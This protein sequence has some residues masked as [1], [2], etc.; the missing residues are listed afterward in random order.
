MTA[1]KLPCPNIAGISLSEQIAALDPVS[2]AVQARWTL[3]KKRKIGPFEIVMAFL[4]VILRSGSSYSRLAWAVGIPQRM[5]VSRQAVHKRMTKPFTEFLRRLVG[6]AM[7]GR[8]AETKVEVTSNGLFRAFSSVVLH[9]STCLAVPDA[10]SEHFPGAW[11]GRGPRKAMLKVDTM[12]DITHW[13]LIYLKVIPYNQNDQAQAGIALE[14]VGKGML[15][16]RDLGYF[17]IGAFAEIARKEAFFLS[18]LKYGIG[19]FDQ[20]GRRL[21]LDTLLVDGQ[22]LDLR[23]L[24]GA[25][26][27]QVRLVAIP[28]PPAEAAERRRKA[29]KD[30]DRRKKHSADYMRRLGWTLIVT[31]VGEDTWATGQVAEAYRSRWFVETLFKSWKSYLN[32]AGQPCPQKPKNSYKREP[33]HPHK[34]EAVVLAFLLL[35]VLAQMPMIARGIKAGNHL[36]GIPLI[37]MLKLASL[38]ADHVI[39]ATIE[40]ME[41]IMESAQYFCRYDKRKRPNALSKLMAQDA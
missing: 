37:S 33:K 8:L 25:E 32:L 24:M 29:G 3:R 10:L 7:L 20:A 2:E 14:A 23:L 16:I 28:L 26:Q 9:D 41:F 11:N 13:S 30:R 27:L 6:K 36:N 17:V 39:N 34:A 31:N 18:R 4:S 15:V 19:L 1:K 38:V 22:A 40:Q 35:A 5:T 12:L 21:D